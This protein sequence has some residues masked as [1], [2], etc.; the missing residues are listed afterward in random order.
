MYR[1][2]LHITAKKGWI[3]DPNGFIY[4]NGKYHL[5]AQHNPNSVKWDTM[6]WL[7]FTSE[8][9]VTFNEEGI[10]LFPT[11]E[12]EKFYGCFSGSAMVHGKTLYLLYT[13]ANENEQVQCLATSVDGN[14]FVKSHF[15]PVISK[16]NL[17]DDF[18]V[19]DF[20]DP[21]IIEKDDVFYV[22]IGARRKDKGVSLLLYKTLDFRNYGFINEVM[23]LEDIN[24]GMIE[25]PDVI[26][27]NK[28]KNE[29]C[30]I[31][32]MQFK[33]KIKNK[34]Q[35]VHSTVYQTGI[36]DLESGVLSHL[37]DV[38]E[39]DY[40]FDF[41]ATQTLQRDGKSY[42]VAWENMWDRNYPSQEEG[43]VGQFTFIR[44][45]KIIDN[46]MYQSFIPSI[47]NYYT[48]EYCLN[49]VHINSEFSDDNLSSRN[50][51]IEI[52]IVSNG[53]YKISVEDDF[54]ITVSVIN[55]NITVSRNNMDIEIVN[56]D[57]TD[58]KNRIIDI[59]D[60]LTHLKLDMIIDNSCIDILIN[61]GKYSFSST[62]FKKIGTKFKI[63]PINNNSEV[64][65]NNL[66]KHGLG[67]KK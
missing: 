67:V 10:I 18:I 60:N 38:K 41:Y 65:I 58:A 49:N 30:L 54:D 25:C 52:E 37:S 66:I 31:Y 5:F 48:D 9:L 26:F 16:Y 6:H 3:N 24:N 46:L 1:P 29:I 36:I 17:P 22:F 42:L 53:D 50:C 4:Y 55:N 15:N 61:D 12:Y 28:E 64:I 56:K 63:T 19:A 14:H 51:R 23:R 39:V 44:E 13:G 8:D 7:H 34:F 59:D 21:K 11:E 32:C 40:G 57:L 43:Y 47:K 2:K 62:Y 20:R 27:T 33:E 45:I 35:N